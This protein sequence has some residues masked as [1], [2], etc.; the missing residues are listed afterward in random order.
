MEDE[1]QP[2]TLGDYSRPSHEGN[3]IELPEGDNVLPLRSD[4]IHLVLYGCP[5]SDP[6]KDATAFI[7]IFLLRSS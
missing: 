7:S 6:G 5:F 1:S 3:T 2:R 4:T